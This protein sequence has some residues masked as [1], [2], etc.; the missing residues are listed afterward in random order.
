MVKVTLRLRPTLFAVIALLLAAFSSYAA[1]PLPPPKVC[2]EFFKAKVVIIGTVTAKQKVDRPGEGLIESWAYQLSVTRVLKGLAADPLMVYSE[3]GSAELP[4][5][6][7]SSYLL[8]VE[9]YKGSL[10]IYSCGNS[11]PISEAQDKIRQ[12][13]EIGMAA[14]GA[15]EG[16]VVSYL[17]APRGGWKGLEAVRVVATGDTGEHSVVTNGDGW[18]HIAVPP[19]TYQVRAEG[20]P[21]TVVLDLSYDDSDNHVIEKGRCGQLWFVGDAPPGIERSHDFK[22]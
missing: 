10:L 8:F 22:W 2:G 5:Q 19:G 7:G 12:I 14:N 17:P 16:R 20:P 13:E 11:R 15:I 1:C 6:V 18:F 4:L 21:P 9:E 3:I